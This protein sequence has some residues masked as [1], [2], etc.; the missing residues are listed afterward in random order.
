MGTHYGSEVNSNSEEE[1]QKN[2]ISEADLQAN[3][4]ISAAVPE[5]KQRGKPFDRSITFQRKMVKK[6][7]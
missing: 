4:K 2:S 5:Q 1:D 3:Y 6:F 7:G